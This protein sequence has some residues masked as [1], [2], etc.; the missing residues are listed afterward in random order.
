MYLHRG[1][2]LGKLSAIG[3]SILGVKPILNL[4][5]NGTL[6]LKEK[7]RGRSA[8]Y[9]LMVN[10]LIKLVDPDKTSDTI[11]ISHTDCEDEA[12]KLAEMV[13]AAVKVRTVEIIGLGPVIGAHVGP[14]TVTLIFEASITREEYEKSAKE[15]A[16]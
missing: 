7:V 6:A 2:R 5:P 13:K 14:G 15:A 8:A 9:R 1:G 4:K 3:G 10:H 12:K 16:K 11:F